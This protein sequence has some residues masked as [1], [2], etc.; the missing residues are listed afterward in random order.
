M[1]CL[2]LK[3][4]TVRKAAKFEP[5]DPPYRGNYQFARPYTAG[6]TCGSCPGACENKLCSESPTVPFI[7]LFAIV[8]AYPSSQRTFQ[9]SSRRETLSFACVCCSQTLSLQ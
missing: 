1:S 3:V 9:L 4:K 2:L 7:V 8:V 5:F 6:K